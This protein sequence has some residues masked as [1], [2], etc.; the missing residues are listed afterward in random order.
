[1]KY[2][3][4]QKKS[5]IIFQIHTWHLHKLQNK[6]DRMIM[7]QRWSRRDIYHPKIINLAIMTLSL[8]SRAYWMALLFTTTIKYKHTLSSLH[9]NR[10]QNAANDQS[11]SKFCLLNVKS[12]MYNIIYTVKL[13][14]GLTSTDLL[15][16][17]DL[18][19]LMISQIL[20]FQRFD[21]F[22]DLMISQ[23]WWFDRFA[24]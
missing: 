12:D 16:F 8:F 22:T 3:Q 4:K 18:T 15:D 13:K 5:N 9:E 20:W 2:T 14:T 11:E 10:T 19:D 1:M 23:I 17:T 21:D 24:L 7:T 6:P